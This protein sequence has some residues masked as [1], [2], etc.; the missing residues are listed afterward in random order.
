MKTIICDD[1]VDEAEITREL[2]VTK[3]LAEKED[4]RLF[5]P[6]ELRTEIEN[7]TLQCDIAIMDIEFEK[8][9]YNGINLSAA[10][11]KLLPSTQIIYL[12]NILEFA[13]DVYD[14]RHCYFVLKANMELMLPRAF[15]KAENIINK[16]ENVGVMEIVSDGRRM[17][18]PQKDIVYVERV[19][20]KLII[21]TQNDSYSSY[22]SLRKFL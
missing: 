4:V 17:L 7:G 15:E 9:S 16:N 22:G 12:T 6:D 3:D 2:I 19:Q 1:C 14:T 5:L 18:I 13:P 20:R 21:H 10:I 8:D 11:N